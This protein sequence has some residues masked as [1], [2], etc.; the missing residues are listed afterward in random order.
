MAGAFAELWPGRPA[1]QFQ[2]VSAEAFYG[3][4]YDD[5]Q[6]RVPDIRKAQQRLGFRPQKS[7]ADALPAIVRDYSERYG[8]RV[9]AARPKAARVASA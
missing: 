6:E 5:T 1:A 2:A 3:P 7:L 9:D 4:G 8:A